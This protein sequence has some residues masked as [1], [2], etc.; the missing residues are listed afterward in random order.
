MGIMP[1][2]SAAKQPPKGEA[3]DLE[4]RFF[5]EATASTQNDDGVN[6][7]LAEQLWK[8]SINIYC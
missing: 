5:V 3:K 2:L 1:I 8:N 4:F 6:T 7:F